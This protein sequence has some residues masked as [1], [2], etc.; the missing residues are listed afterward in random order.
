[1]NWKYKALLQSTL[2]FLP[3]GERLNLLFQRYATRSLPAGPATFA[4][5]VTTARRHFDLLRQHVGYG[6][7]AGR[8]YEF[9]AGWDLTVALALYAFG[10]QRQ[11]LIDVRRLSSALLVNEAIRNFERVS[12]SVPLNRKPTRVLPDGPSFIRSLKEEYGIDYQA[13][14][15]ARRTGFS[16]SSVDFITSS[17]TLEHIPERDIGPILVECHR[18]LQ[19]DGVMSFMIDYQDHYSYFDPTIS[20]YNFLRHSDQTWRFFSSSLHYQNRL[21]HPDYVR[22]MQDARFEVVEEDRVEGSADDL[23]TIRRLPLAPRFRT[24]GLAELAIRSSVLVMRK[25]GP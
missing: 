3:A 23:Q 22:A 11:L 14:H 19:D 10:V 5:R 4:S 7:E 12:L 20:A 1:V 15:D 24:Y 6:I 18:L 2:S 13:P 17:Y 9:G 21:R 25:R 16:A 8:F